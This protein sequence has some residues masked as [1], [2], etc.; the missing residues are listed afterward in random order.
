MLIFLMFLTPRFTVGS[1]CPRTAEAAQSQ[2]K[3]KKKG[4]NKNNENNYNSNNN[5]VTFFSKLI[6]LHIITIVSL[7]VHHF[8]VLRKLEVRNSS[9]NLP[10][11]QLLD[12]TSAAL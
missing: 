5:L 10:L 11:L 12:V 9:N 7:K 2:K 8:H 1:T 4:F 3:K 6:S